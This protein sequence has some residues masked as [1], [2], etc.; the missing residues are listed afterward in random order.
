MEINSNINPVTYS[1]NN[2]IEII[3]LFCNEE[4][5]YDDNDE[6]EII[7][8]SL[9]NIHKQYEEYIGLEE[10]IELRLK[11]NMYNSFYISFSEIEEQLE[12]NPNKNLIVNLS[13]D[14]E[15]NKLLINLYKKMFV[16]FDNVEVTTDKIFNKTRVII[17]QNNKILK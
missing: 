13:T 9:K 15:T 5:K 4:I 6:Y 8:N 2:S 17:K 12:K 7:L 16:I 1:V 3:E 10:N 14:K 11:A